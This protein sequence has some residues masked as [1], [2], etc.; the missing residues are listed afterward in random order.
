MFRRALF[1]AAVLAVVLIFSSVG[2][3][4][5]AAV[6]PT[7]VV[8]SQLYGGGGNAGSTYKNDFIELFNPTASGIDLT[9]SSVQYA[10]AAGTTWQVTSLSGTISPGAYY[11]VQE[12]VGAG[13]T[14]ALPAPDATGT[15]AMSAT[16]GKVAF[17]TS[18][19][20]LTGTC[21][22]AVDLVGFGATAN[23]FEGAAA[24]PAPSNT[25]ADLRANGG[26]QDGNDNATDFATGAPTP[27]N[28]VSP[29][30][31]C[32]SDD[33]PGVASTSPAA[34]ATGIAVDSNVSIT[35]SEPVNVS[36]NWYAISCGTSGAH[37]AAATGGPT[38]FTLDPDTSF[39]N[40]ETCTVTISAAQVSDQ[41]PVDPPDTM[42]SDYTFSFTTAA[43]V[44]PAAGAVI[45][46][47]YGGGGNSGATLTNDFIELFNP[48]NADIPLTGASVQYA[49]ATGTGLW[50][51]TNLSG[52]LGAHHYYL[53]QEAVGAGGT[54]SLPTPD[55]TGT[56][57][58][59]ATAGKVAL[60]S[61]QTALSGCP[62]GLVDLVGFG[63]TANCSESAPT[64]AP[65]N[66]TAVLRANGGCT[67][68]NNNAADF[69]AGPPNPRNASSPTHSCTGGD[70]AQPTIACGSNLTTPQGTPVSTQ[71][72]ATDT[73][74]V[75]TSIAITSVAPASAQSSFA[76]T[77]LSPAT[78]P[79]DTATATL[80]A[81]GSL[82]PG[83]YT[84]H[85]QAANNDTPPQTAACTLTVTV[86]GMV[87]IGAVQGSVPDSADGTTFASPLAG[88][89]VTVHGIV[90]ELTFDGGN[91][92]FYLQSTAATADSDPLSSDGIFV[93]MGHFTDLVNHYVPVVGDEIVLTGKVSEFFNQTELG[94]ATATKVGTGS[95]TPFAADPPSDSA[96]AARYW[97]RH[98]G[99]QAAIQTG[100]IVDSP[101]HFYASTGDTEF[102][103]IAPDAPVALRTDP[104][105]R[106]AF[107][108]AHPL[109]DVPGTFD[110]GNGYKILVTDEGI[111]AG[112]PTAE[113]PPVHTFQTV[114]SPASGGVFYDFGK[115]SV[116]VSSQPQVADGV[117]PAQNDPPQAFD[118]SQAYSIVNYNMENLYDYRDD[119]FDGCD[120]DG[121]SGCPGVSPP[122]DYT[123][124]NDAEYQQRETE[125]AHQVIDD[126]HGPD[127]IVVAEAEDQDICTVQS[128]Q[129]VCGTTNNADGK[130][131][132]LQELAV[133]I[134][135]L[136]GPDYD[137]AFDRSS[138]DAR[139]II[140]A[141]MY[142]TDRVQ[143]LPASSSD[144]VLGSS[145]A[146]QYRGA[147]LPYDTDVS[148][149]K[150]L[151][152]VLPADVDRSTGVDGTNVFTRA[153]QVAHFRFSPT[154]AP[155]APSDVWIVANHFTSG[156]DSS[157]GQRR[158]QAAYNAAIVRAIQ[159][160]EPNAKIM[161]AGDLNEYPR[162][163]DP[164]PPPATT[165]QLA[166]L[167]DAGLHNLYDTV[168]ERDPASAYSYNFEGQA[169]D[170][171]HQFVSDSLFADLQAV[172]EAH[173]NSDFSLDTSGDN[174]GTSDHDPMVSRWAL[175]LDRPPT[176][177]AGG[178]YTVDE[179]S[180]V[181]LAATGSDPDGDAVSYAWDLD[182]NGTFETPGQSVS[183]AAGDGPATVTVTVRATDP[184]GLTATG[185]ATITVRNAPPTATLV[186]PASAPAGFAFSLSMTNPHDAS[187]ADTAAGFTYAF[188]C[189][190]GSGFSSWSTS[191]KATCPT[192][193]VGTRS[194]AGRIRD[195]DGGIG[196]QHATVV[197]TVTT[198]S[199][200]TLVRSYVT[201]TDIE[202]E[203]CDKL[204]AIADAD[205]KNKDTQKKIA[206]FQKKVRAD[207]PRW[208]TAAQADV[209]IRLSEAL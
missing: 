193:D 12:A 79:G 114:S 162:P 65:S 39:A 200:C 203:L 32:A 104:Y 131:D 141:F 108:D 148:N 134:H 120:F 124:A 121:N 127:V 78:A 179:G 28:S 52:T 24:A 157:V 175:T 36:G 125:I 71:V 154:S 113:L 11:L 160:Q 172:N 66:T 147:P 129:V 196:E 145:P 16:A 31:F 143:L 116:S 48:T 14:T 8:V 164:F 63:S 188:D 83:A 37:T 166:P 40:G 73:D 173:I 80:T 44:V 72:S 84:V 67:D 181:T 190:D 207:V 6:D 150:S 69:A 185:S 135:A 91:N 100:S 9:G 87:T 105:A 110:N 38:T 165:D 13:G 123:P 85:L 199:I 53:V 22:S 92:G 109:D 20:A 68:T 153:A 139:G 178:P 47:V 82:A 171:D 21:P 142:R 184:S 95:V 106:R 159:S 29:L 64:P 59:A 49:S 146:V 2:G 136:G 202:N 34:G 187:P 174:R 161:V 130:P 192:N 46:Q 27:R 103:V 5:S 118:R 56:I 168:I 58:M 169:Q 158:E 186:A 209:L 101:R 50:A 176:V 163:D 45:S 112:A 15:I 99:M 107:R 86:S 77:N 57:A 23:C 89:T 149:P 183:F 191:S 74:G 76:V 81:D 4:T 128:W 88:Q 7:G 152:A 206:D 102:Y 25:A 151:N 170:L 201:N 55:A 98:E 208:L 122:F 62:S 119:P 115:Y 51:V 144:A 97:E 33:P 132:D 75:V 180:A 70:N 93:F 189:G 43:P 195:Q 26:C 182:G 96:D 18:T 42:T 17:V 10:A 197:L 140:P 35:F 155:G 94:S 60:V 54:T 1:A 61:S 194:V 30:H 205:A 126:L 41:D 19:T 117:D 204:A 3:A 111:K 133:H 90:T 167:Y 177:T 138:T 156:P 137:A 198:D